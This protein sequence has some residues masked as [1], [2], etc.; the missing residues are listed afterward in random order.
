MARMSAI[1]LP[2]NASR[3]TPHELLPDTSGRIVKERTGPDPDG[4][5]RYIS[6]R[7]AERFLRKKSS[8]QC[9][10]PPPNR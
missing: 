5:F 8:V 9:H 3:S 4:R 7:H 10:M 2:P 1:V 6:V